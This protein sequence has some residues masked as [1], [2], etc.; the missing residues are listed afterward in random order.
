MWYV[1]YMIEYFF[2]THSDGPPTHSLSRNH[3]IRSDQLAPQHSQSKLLT[4]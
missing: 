1:I 3:L 4:S 2:T